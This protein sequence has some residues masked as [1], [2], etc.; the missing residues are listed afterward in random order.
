MTYSIRRVFLKS[1]R[2]AAP[3]L[4]LVSLIS[5]AVR[6]QDFRGALVGAVVDS[7]G[8][9]IP[10]ARVSVRLENPVVEREITTTTDGEFRLDN[11]QPGTYHVV[12]KAKGFA[13]AASDVAVVVG[14]VRAITVTLHPSS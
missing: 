3:V 7:S 4:F 14:S 6:A 1:F 12:V 13:D 10:A 8:A 9:R 5:T 11:L 2:V